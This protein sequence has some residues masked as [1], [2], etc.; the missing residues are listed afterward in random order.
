[1]PKKKES[2]LR[3]RVI[4]FIKTKGMSIRSFEESIGIPN[5]SISQYTD[6]T[7]KDTL[8]RIKDFYVDFDIDYIIT[9]VS[10]DKN[11]DTDLISRE[12]V[13]AMIEERKRHD[14]ERKRHDE[15]N[16]E[17]IRQNGSLLR[18]LEEKEKTVVQTEV[19]SAAVK[20]MSGLQE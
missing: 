18:M 15:M 17:L 7:S 14:E 1:M 8:K 9:G 5:G 2:E 20:S 11:I 4:E 12:L 6:N 3:N 19:A 16:A 10:V 13:Q